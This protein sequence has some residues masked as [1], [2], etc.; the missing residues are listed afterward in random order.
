MRLKGGAPSSTPDTWSADPAAAIGKHSY[1]HAM[2]VGA[3]RKRDHTEKVGHT[4]Q[5]PN[6]VQFGP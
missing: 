3:Q 4:A 5:S 1:N 2:L 6:L